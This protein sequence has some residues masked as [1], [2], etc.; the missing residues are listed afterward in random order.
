MTDGRLSAWA[1]AWMAIDTAT[2]LRTQVHQKD[3]SAPLPDVYWAMLQEAAVFVGL[4]QVGADVGIPVAD[5]LQEQERQ[6]EEAEARTAKAT[7]SFMSY[8]DKH[9][10]TCEFNKNQCPVH[11]PD[12]EPEE[13]DDDDG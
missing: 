1:A 7:E 4:A 5:W 2:R 3:V 13:T 8:A 11:N 10:C 12:G 6:R 9:S